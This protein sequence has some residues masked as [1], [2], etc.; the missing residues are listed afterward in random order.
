MKTIR[1]TVIFL[2]MILLPAPLIYG[3]DLSK[4]RKFSLGMSLAQV[5]KQIGTNSNGPSLIYERPAVIQELTSV[6]LSS[7]LRSSEQSD[8]APR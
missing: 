6:S 5:S 2:V 1:H 3:Q 7:S 8:P 4:Y